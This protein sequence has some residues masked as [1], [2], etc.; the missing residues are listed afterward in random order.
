M[1]AASVQIAAQ[2]R[3]QSAL[4][5]RNTVIVRPRYSGIDRKPRSNQNREVGRH[6]R[7]IGRAQTTM[8]Q[9]LH[10]MRRLLQHL[11]GSGLALAFDRLRRDMGRFN[12]HPPI[13]QLATG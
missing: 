5:E 4:R 11:L 6:S 13:T 8:P 9:R 2:Q 10:A 1:L 3:G 12:A 7:R